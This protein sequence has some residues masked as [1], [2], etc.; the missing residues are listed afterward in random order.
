MLPKVDE[1][2][3]D[4]ARRRQQSLH[5][6]RVVAAESEAPGR[7]DGRAEL[8]ALLQTAG[9]R[10]NT[11]TRVSFSDLLEVGLFDLSTEILMEI[12]VQISNLCGT[13]EGLRISDVELIHSG[14]GDLGKDADSPHQLEGG[15]GARRPEHG[16]AQFSRPLKEQ[17]K[18]TSGCCSPC[19]LAV[20][21]PSFTAS[22]IGAVC[23]FSLQTL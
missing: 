5:V 17:C 21:P 3:G 4:F 9:V 22:A 1:E 20:R 14:D 16:A 23:N 2:V 12:C 15:N 13:L 11:G 19:R 7:D 6:A 8:Q 18:L 10:Q